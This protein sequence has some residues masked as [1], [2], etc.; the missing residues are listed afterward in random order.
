MNTAMT[1]KTRTH[2]Y[3]L[4]EGVTIRGFTFGVRVYDVDIVEGSY[5]YNAASDLDYYGYS[6]CD[7]AL[8]V[9]TLDDKGTPITVEALD[10]VGELT[11]DEYQQINSLVITDAYARARDARDQALI[12]RAI[13]AREDARLLGDVPW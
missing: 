10:F 11:E 8:T 13:E 7:W 3:D 1:A 5:S 4:H 6:E 12:D 9:E 2:L